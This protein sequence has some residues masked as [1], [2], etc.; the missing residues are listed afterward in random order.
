MAALTIV[1]ACGNEDED[2]KPK[3]EQ[4][5]DQN[6]QQNSGDN[7]Q[8]V[9]NRVKVDCGRCHGDGICSVCHGTGK[10]CEACGG[11]GGQCD[12]CNNTGKYCESCNTTGICSKCNGTG[13][14]CSDCK[15]SGQCWDCNG[16]GY[17]YKCYGSG[18][19][20][21]YIC[22]G[23]GRNIISKQTCY[24][25]GGSGKVSCHMCFGTGDCQ[26]CYG[27]KKCTTCNGHPECS[28]CEGSRKCKACGGTAICSK[29]Q[30]HP[31]C[32]VCGGDGHCT[33]C[34]NRNGK[35]KYCEGLGYIW[36]YDYKDG[37]V[38]SSDV[39]IV[40]VAQFNAAEE[41]RDVWYQLTGFVKGFKEGDKYGNFDLE[42]ATGSVY[43]YGLLSEKGGARKE[44]Q[45]LVNAKGIKNGSKITIIGNRGEYNKRV[46]VLNAYFVSIEDE[47]SVS[48]N[49]AEIDGILYHLE[50][51]EATVMSNGYSGKVVIPYRFTSNEITYYVTSIGDAAFWGC[52]NLTSV[53]LPSGLRSI[54]ESAFSAC[55]GLTSITIPNTVTSIG[56][57]AFS[58]CSGLTS[59]KI[60]KNVK[61]IGNYAFCDCRGLTSVTSYITTPIIIDKNVFVHFDD[62]YIPVLYVP[63]GTKLLY[64]Q[65]EGWY[66]N[67][68]RI[69]EIG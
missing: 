65:A 46:E 25:C 23:L 39:Q 12:Q 20:T 27:S 32:E 68:S 31:G 19:L 63:A 50:G 2:V 54:G 44:F 13:Y 56:N 60:P 43:V 9:V 29:C 34:I 62:S 53:V 3:E 11:T 1:T 18:R 36:E 4:N 8:P 16:R 59:I 61:S 58:S 47:N 41:S 67:F 38:S 69:E 49:E 7:D 64:E 33:T 52:T 48:T 21:C 15:G 10:G 37:N 28:S 17:C 24:K 45:D 51:R 42:D 66:E 6:G 55:H 5:S 26:I 57:F 35:C 22:D 30:G 14:T 40:T